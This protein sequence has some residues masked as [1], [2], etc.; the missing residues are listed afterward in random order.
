MCPDSTPRSGCGGFR[1]D[2]AR[3]ARTIRKLLFVP[4]LVVLSLFPSLGRAT[5]SVYQKP[6]KAVLDVLHA[7][8]L[9]DASLDPMHTT[10]VLATPVQFPSIAELSQPFLKLAGTRVV[11]RNRSLYDSS[12]WTA[13]DLVKVA[14][15]SVIHVA[16]PTGAKV[17]FP[18]FSADGKRY[19]FNVITPDS[20]ELWAGEANKS[21]VRKI[22]GVRLNPFFGSEVQWM[23]DQKTLIVK[24]VPKDEGKAPAVL[25]VPIGPDVK[26][27]AGGKASSTYE[28]RDVLTSE[29]DEANFD[30]YGATQL[31]LVDFTSGKV[32]LIGKPGLHMG[33][34][35][36]PDGHLLVETIHRPYSR[37]TA[38]DR[39]P[40]E[41]E[42]WDRG[43]KP[44][45]HVASL[46]L[47]ESVPIW[48]VP[49]G[50]REFQWRSTSPATLF[51]LEAQD[52]GDWN[53]KVP[54]RDRVMA[55]K[56]PFEG[57]AVEVLRTEMRFGGFWW[58]EARGVAFVTEYD[59]IKHWERLQLVDIDAAG[60]VPRKVWERSSD[61]RYR[62]PG[63]PVF[64]VLP[65]GFWVVEQ[66][67]DTIWLRGQGASTEGDR[68][69]LDKF[70]LKMLTFERLWR[71]EK[72]AYEAF[73]GWIDRSR[74]QFLIRH[75][76]PAEPPNYF[77]RLLGERQAS[78]PEGEARWTSTSTRRVTHLSDPTPQLRSIT[79]KL[80]TYKRA[81]GV[82]L[83]FTLYLPPGYKEG[84]R[85]PA[86]LNA[87][88]LDYTDPK[89]AGQ[90]SGSTQR[91]T[92]ISWQHQLF[93]LLEGYAVI[94]NPSLPV[95]GDGNRIYDTYMEQLIAG[96]KAAV[97]KAVELGV[98]DRD[99][100]GVMGHSHGGLM[101][102]NL[103]THSDLF[104]SGIARSGAYNRSLTAFGFQN[105]R[106]T[107]WEATDV[108]VK[109][110]P[111]FHVDKLKLPILLI[112]GEVDVNPGTV[113]LQSEL[114]YEAIRGNGG[115]ARLVML[116]FESHGYSAMESNEHVLAESIAWFD[117]YVKNAPPRSQKTVGK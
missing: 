99:R 88:P 89:M 117:K 20:V 2:P 56:A 74:G 77:V 115:T 54:H 100:I 32:T 79:K 95:V 18:D 14:D 108:Y 66:E 110:S 40:R 26:E 50:P 47:A 27:T 34:S 17:G 4:I 16:L 103:L 25:S 15:G 101:T 59:A 55:W 112:H 61:E 80:V 98:V 1:R 5:D 39:F 48:G 96:A 11:L 19:V 91:F 114:L 46:P 38:Y 65:N 109:V 58:S 42:V 10:M 62:N 21:G 8:P 31:A 68:P 104:R 36:S 107:L 73:A 70:D 90:V 49:T 67:G 76:N 53:T 81:D 33:V 3:G 71:C 86:V 12:Y 24:M 52:G 51:W 44:V 105:E 83:S 35:M 60:S 111:F 45:K 37:V 94:D 84:T 87:Y 9:P 63:Y 29:L 75:E 6:P 64:R 43:G 113:P 82:D 93:F 85:L 30:Y 13:I 116:P 72:T 41:V 102:V 97:D 106:R 92:T 7:P 22:E 28:V 69:F 23:A 57:E 78:A